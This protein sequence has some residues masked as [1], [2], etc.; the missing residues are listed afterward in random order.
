ML[1]GKVHGKSPKGNSM[2]PWRCLIAK[3]LHPTWARDPDDSC[4]V[5]VKQMTAI[6]TVESGKPDMSLI[7][8]SNKTHHP[9]P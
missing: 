6:A 8:G 5:H 4:I 3:G 2:P 9:S 1:R 7:G